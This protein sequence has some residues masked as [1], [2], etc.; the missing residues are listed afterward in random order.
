MRI[1]DYVHL[2]Y[3]GYSEHGIYREGKSAS[4][5]E[6][7]AA[8][9]NKEYEKIKSRVKDVSDTEAKNI[10][11]GLT[12]F[13]TEI[14]SN[15][16]EAKRIQ[17]DIIELMKDEFN[18]TLGQIHYDSLYVS[19]KEA[20]KKRV[21][22][23]IDKVSI[24]ITNDE[25]TFKNSIRNK[26]EEINNRISK[27]K[28]SKKESDNVI[29]LKNKL[30]VLES[31][32][33]ELEKT[34]LLQKGISNIEKQRQMK[35]IIDRLN[36]IINLYCGIPALPLQKGELFEFLA[37]YWTLK[38]RDEAEGTVTTDIKKA[39]NSGIKVGQEKE[40]IQID[41]SKFGIEDIDET[42][43][44]FIHKF[45]TVGDQIL[46]VNE[47]Q[48]KIDVNLDLG[49]GTIG[50]SLK[51]Y[52][53]K[54]KLYKGWIH[55]VSGTN[56]LLYLQ[57]IAPEL[58]NHYLNLNAA[59]EGNKKKSNLKNFDKEAENSRVVIKNIIAAKAITGAVYERKASDVFIVNDSRKGKI[60]VVSMYK[61]IDAIKKA[62]NSSKI[63][64][65]IGNGENEGTSITNVHNFINKRQPD[66]SGEIRIGNML[67]QLHSM[68]MNSGIRQDF[69]VDIHDN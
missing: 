23:N 12:A 63:S 58:V 69:F 36:S 20:Y 60:R 6:I 33:N 10:E 50:A 27:L 59:H 62:G 48:G 1:G 47:S 11:E 53:F 64:V 40:K 15:T 39:I 26:I 7:V 67:R 13:M 2:T 37:A 22:G 5:S 8:K 55:T 56:L 44:K 38:M 51:N 65:K 57:D 52:S 34:I 31:Q 28:N 46:K 42:G 16:A 3:Q 32:I 4:F 25:E 18:N 9:E 45:F 30:D 41:S 14:N 35:K 54:D 21:I 68:K 43:K 61:L 17:K 24:K 66:E 19:N 49:S 29:E